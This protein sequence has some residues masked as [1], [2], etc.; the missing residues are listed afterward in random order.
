LHAVIIERRQAV[1]R[2]G[3]EAHHLRFVCVHRQRFPVGINSEPV[4]HGLQLVMDIGQQ[5]GV[6][7]KQHFW[8]S[9]I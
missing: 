5:R 8:D 9:K 1:I 2:P 3:V 7:S 6:I 4:E